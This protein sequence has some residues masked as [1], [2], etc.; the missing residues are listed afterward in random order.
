MYR[1]LIPFLLLVPLACPQ[2]GQLDAS[3][4]LFSVL[5]A[6]NAAGYDA[7]LDSP[8]NHPLRAQVRAEI[9][10][11]KPAV[12][13]DLQRFYRDHKLP[14]AAAELSQYISFALSTTGPPDF[15]P[16]F[17]QNEI[18]PDVQR[19]E[20][21]DEIMRRFHREAG[22]DEQWKKAQPAFDQIIAHYHEGVV[23]SVLEANGYL[24]NAGT[25]YLGHR[26]QIFL[27][28]L[29][30]PNQIQFH[31]Y[32]DDFY[33]VITSSPQPQL[34][35]VRHGY[36]TFM[37]EPLAMKYSDA[38][39]K[40]R[41]LI[42]YAQA[43]PALEE[44][45]KNDFLLLA[46]KSLVKAVES[47]MARSGGPA[48]VEQ[49]LREGYVLAPHFAEQLA[50]YEKQE[51]SMR[52][53]FP[54]L[55][56]SIDLKREERRL[57]NVQF[58]SERAVRRAKPSTPAPKRELTGPEK[59]LEEAENLYSA[60]QL[61]KA[62]EVYRKLLEQ[63]EEKPLHARA[64]YGLAR[65]AAFQKDPELAEKLFHKT[66]ETEPDPQVKSWTYVYLG[67]LAGLAGERE[68]AAQ[69][70]RAA[71]ACEGASPAAHDAAEK[72]LKDSLSK[73]E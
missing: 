58:A 71:L 39:M 2:E 67:R 41:G 59:T 17:R 43:A 14:S 29:G 7:A 24:R 68:Q 27:D 47:R 16:G 56:S 45:Y 13:S 32:K 46:T 28:L 60:R 69:H 34:N 51:Q 18:P 50:A 23:R 42:D 8:S 57:E 1:F 44:H 30:A 21:F 73:K 52:F 31:R 63:T 5:A 26:F 9:V 61:D 53:Y 25:G 64:Y 20:G 49:A 36:L 66:L 10:R 33:V 35:D 70:Y 38:L 6:V 4:S 15:K 12:M 62:R 19:L 40:N 22:M 72:G 54:E 65:I 11:R 3:P 55:V 48:L 37:L